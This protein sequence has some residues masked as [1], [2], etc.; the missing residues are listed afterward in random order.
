MN[1]LYITNHLNIG[2]I[3]N[4]VLSLGK[5]L[6]KRGHNIYVASSKGNLLSRFKE[7]GVTFIPIPINT[8]SEI[9][10]K[11]LFSRSRLIK[12]IKENNIEIMHANSRTTQVL[13]CLLSRRTGVP[14]ISTCHGFFKQRFSRRIFPCWGEKVIAISEPVREHLIRDFR[15]SD[16]KISVIHHGIDVDCYNLE[17]KK[18]LGLGE[19]PVVGIVARLSDVKGHIYLIEAM[20]AVLDKVPLAQLLIVGDGKMKKTLV[21]LTHQLR[22]EKSIKFMPSVADTREVLSMMDLFVLP[23]L[24]EGLGLSLM[25]AMA[26]GLG[27]IA[28]DIGG[29]K[30]L[31]Q[32]GHNGLLVKP[33]DVRGLSLAILELLNDPRKREEL[34][35]NAR[36]FI[37]NNFSF[38]KMVT[39]TER[40]YSECVKQR[41]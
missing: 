20:K 2:G 17:K 15:V 27:V 1:I 39:E 26:K 21:K 22:L 32:N 13:A 7:E 35:S 33:A 31:I 28:S 10:P 23:S 34:G 4:Y 19:G 12:A 14:Y 30:S 38:D 16:K 6:K 40:I 3:T 24:K 18:E 29:I 41:Y 36:E 8:K 9:S 11:I 5:A 37:K 25:E